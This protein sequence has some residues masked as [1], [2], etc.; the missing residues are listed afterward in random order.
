MLY[1]QILVRMLPEERARI[2]GRAAQYAKD[3][4]ICG[5]HYESDIE[6]GKRA[7]AIEAQAML[8]SSAFQRDFDAARAEI[9]AALSLRR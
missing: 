8:K 3:R 7:G 5:V 1:A 2:F 4:V 9:R 6:A